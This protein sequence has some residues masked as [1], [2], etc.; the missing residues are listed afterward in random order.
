MNMLLKTHPISNE[1]VLRRMTS[2]WGRTNNG[3]HE[4]AMVPPW[5]KMSSTEA[6]SAM[7]LEEAARVSAQTHYTKK[8][9]EA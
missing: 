1:F 5:V 4:Y 6:Y 7:H 3:L 8:N 2:R 9:E